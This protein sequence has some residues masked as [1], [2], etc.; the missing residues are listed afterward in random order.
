MKRKFKIYFSD[1]FDVSPESLKQH[2][3]FN[4]SLLY[5]LPLFIDPFLLF[6]SE[7]TEYQDLH[8]QI[9]EYVK[10]LKMK[11][12]TKL[13]NGEI[14]SWYL[15][16]EIKQ[17]WLGYSKTGNDGRGLGKSF[18]IALN[19]NLT[20]IFKNFG[21][22]TDT[23]PHLEKLTLVKDGVGKDQI[24]D[25]TCN[26]I[27]GFLAKYTEEYAQKYIPKE[28][29]SLFMIPKSRFNWETQTW[30]SR[31]YNL[32]KFGKQYVLLSPVDLLTKDEA[33]INH[34]E[35][36][37][38]FSEVVNGVENDQLR[39]EINNYLYNTLPEKP[40]KPDWSKAIESAVRKYPYLIDTFIAMKERNREGATRVSAEKIE[41]TNQIF[42]EH[43]KQFIELISDTEFYDTPTNSFE[44]GLKRVNYL[45]HVIENQDGYR[46]FYNKNRPIKKESDLQI[47]FKLTWFASAYDNNAEVNNGRGP[48]DFIVS[49][50]SKDKTVIEFKLASNTKLETNLKNQ[51]EIYSDAARATHPPIKAILYFTEAEHDKVWKLLT[52][53]K[54][55]KKKEIVLIDA[56]EKVSASKERGNELPF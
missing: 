28:K 29:L 33:W 25:F 16:P 9:I 44:E 19:H 55:E 8:K 53:H 18:A 4:I 12:A 49:Y 31:Q 6:N 48:A 24:S 34:R 15:F 1:F 27:L 52:K 13:S 30:A 51:A 10:F 3:A 21:E 38:D 20:T 40:K 5:D 54:L 26:L 43:I 35:F 46:L 42:I 50:G 17:N 37:E 45:K 14:K 23:S 47:M 2:G 11:S 7:K 36:V 39:S 56:I 41:E 22:E 32:P